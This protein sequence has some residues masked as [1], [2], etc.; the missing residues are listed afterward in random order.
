MAAGVYLSVGTTAIPNVHVESTSRIYAITSLAQPAP[1]V[2][3]L[4]H[5]KKQVSPQ[6]RLEIINKLSKRPV[7]NQSVLTETTPC[8][9]WSVHRPSDKIAAAVA[10][11]VVRL[12]VLNLCNHAVVSCDVVAAWRP[13][14]NIAHVHHGLAPYTTSW[15]ALVPCIRLPAWGWT[16]KYSR[17]CLHQ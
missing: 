15:K 9:G 13:L 16:Q 1:A 2:C 4:L 3:L 12:I 5:T 11:P 10:L 8:L 7:Q 17:W 6:S 14:Q